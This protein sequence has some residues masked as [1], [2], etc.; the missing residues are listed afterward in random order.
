VAISRPT[1]RIELA[2]AFREAVRRLPKTQRRQIGRTLDAIR[3]GF[4]RAHVH[5]GLGIRRLRRNYFECRAGLR[6]RL[7]F[8]A[9]RGTLTFF[10]AGDHDA[11]RRLIKGL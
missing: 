7:V 4:G 9:E 3:E 1:L 11:V 5:S 10:A 6:V 8:R 2:P